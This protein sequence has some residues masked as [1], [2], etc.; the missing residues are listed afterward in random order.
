MKKSIFLLFLLLSASIA[1]AAVRLPSIIGSH[2][3]L[4][5]KSAVQLWGWSAPAEKIPIQPSWDTTTY[6][7]V[8]GRGA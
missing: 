6:T 5:Q 8:A 3:V 7:V 4:Q 1:M 2:M